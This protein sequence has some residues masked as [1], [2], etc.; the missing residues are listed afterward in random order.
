M[1]GKSELPHALSI[2]I[3][4]K[5]IMRLSMLATQFASIREGYSSY[6]DTLQVQLGKKKAAF[7]CGNAA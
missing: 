6:A 5:I 2:S 3:E 4:P 1:M 7:P